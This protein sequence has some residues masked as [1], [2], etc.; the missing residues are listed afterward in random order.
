MELWRCYV[1]SDVLWWTAVLELVKPGRHQGRGKNLPTTTS[2]GSWLI[3]FTYSFFY[4]PQRTHRG[5][6]SQHAPQ[7]TWPGGSLC[8]GVSVWGGGGFCP[9]GSLLG[10]PP[11]TVTSGRYTSYWNTFLL[12]ILSSRFALRLNKYS[13]SKL[14]LCFNRTVF[15]RIVQKPFINLC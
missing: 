2:N 8:P 1:G 13:C 11:H 5:S 7:V 9:G 14:K 12:M 15:R 4:R 3:L 10:R 6:L